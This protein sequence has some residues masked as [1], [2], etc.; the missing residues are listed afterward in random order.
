[1]IACDFYFY[2]KVI[3]PYKIV[4]GRTYILKF[5]THSPPRANQ[6]HVHILQFSFLKLGH[7]LWFMLKW[8]VSYLQSRWTST[9]YFSNSWPLHTWSKSR[10][11]VMV[12]TFYSHPKGRSIMGV[13]KVVLG[14]HGPSSMVWSENG[15]C[16]ETI[17]Y[18][19]GGIRGEDLVSYDISQ[20]LSFWENYLVVFVC[21]GFFPKICHAEKV[22]KKS[23]SPEIYVRPTSWRQMWRKFRETMKPCP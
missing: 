16:C 20:T 1:M 22:L 2:L 4:V 13:G 11:L 21:L 7:I 8:L 14:S 9:S 10:D 15:P 5:L 17:A 23:R 6:L 19:V 12:R 3:P 18:F